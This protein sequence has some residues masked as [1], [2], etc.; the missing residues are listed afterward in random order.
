MKTTIAPILYIISMRVLCKLYCKDSFDMY[1][2]NTLPTYVLSI[3]F[4]S[5]LP[6]Q[7]SLLKHHNTCLNE[8]ANSMTRLS[9]IACR[10]KHSTATGYKYI[11][12]IKKMYVKSESVD[13]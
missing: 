9:S 7:T 4:Y 5:I 13:E 2:V 8:K 1:I 10:R 12:F 6:L 3:I 11:F